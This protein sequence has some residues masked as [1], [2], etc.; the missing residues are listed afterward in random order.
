[1]K[2]NAACA[3]PSTRYV[4][5]ALAACVVVAAFFR[6]FELGLS[7]F[8][9]DTILLWSLAQRQ[10]TPG[11]ILARWFEVSGAQGQLPMP[12][13]VM[14]AFLQWLHLPITPFT[15]RLPFALFGV[16]AVPAAF[17][18]G[19]RLAGAGCGLLLAAMVAVNPFH[20]YFSREAYFYSSLFLGYFLYLGAAAGL[21]RALWD[22][23]APRG[24][25]YGLLAAALFL[26]SYSQMSGLLV[27]AAGFLLFAV[28]A[29]ARRRA[30]PAG[31][32]LGILAGVHAAV[33]LPFLFVS[34]GPREMVLQYFSPQTEASKKVVAAAGGNLVTGLARALAE[35][36]WGTTP[37][38]LVLLAMLLLPA[39]VLLATRQ[40]RAGVFLAY[41]LVIQ[42]VLFAMVRSALGA[43]YESRYLAG[44]SPF[45]LCVLAFGVLAWWQWLARRPQAARRAVAVAATAVPL[46]AWCYPAYLDTQ[47]T[48]KPTPYYDIV[49]WT[50]SRLPRGTLV[51]VDRW[52]EPWNE[53]RAH[54][55]TNVYFTFTVPNEPVEAY[56]QNRWRET[57][58]QFFARFPDAAYLEIAKSYW[59][60]PAVGP[61]A[62]PR[63][64]F[65]RHEVFRNR[66]GLALRELGLA[67][68]GD[69]YAANSNRVVVE[70][71][72]NTR[73]DVL[74]AARAD[75]R[76]TL[77][78]Y[79]PEWGHTKPW[80]Q[81]N[82][83][84]DWRV[85]EQRATLDL[86]NLS[87]HSVTGRLVVRGLAVNGDKYVQAGGRTLQ[88]PHG[89]LTE[90]DLGPVTLQPGPNATAL[91]DPQ[92]GRTGAALLV[93]EVE[94]RP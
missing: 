76:T 83:F 66:A 8:R 64:F 84:R 78:L 70:L 31:R 2:K 61:W 15:V 85:L 47:L 40:R 44:L 6:L 21:A 1:M 29:W 19:R 45:W 88:Y 54:P 72:Y 4:Y 42:V 3:L 67:N 90:L 86:Y 16:A 14:Q 34:W 55:S 33:F 39:L 11:M 7:A 68:R 71:F 69:F 13:F 46:L 74:A 38:G 77:A 37:A 73:A 79:G 18:A 48:G 82:D 23:H 63:T 87:P 43:F 28:L 60:A 35:F 62:W 36:S 65:A 10:V 93:D 92:G 94:V 22:G 80:Q 57:A 75:G 91:T 25:D 26:C 58:Q 52:F 32:V 17:Y 50:D 53:L 5:P 24:K 56:L 30:L 12:A 81:L 51:L 20:V 59:D 9:A 41:F 27:C 49:R 89:R